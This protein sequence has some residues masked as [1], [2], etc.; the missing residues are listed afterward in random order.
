MGTKESSLSGVKL[1]FKS[2]SCQNSHPL[3]LDWSP[4][5]FLL[6]EL[7]GWAVITYIL[8]EDGN[9]KASIDVGCTDLTHSTIEHKV[10][11]LGSKANS[12]LLPHENKGEYVTVLKDVNA[13]VLAHDD[14]FYA[15]LLLIL[16][17][18]FVGICAVIDR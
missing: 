4:Y 9:G 13:N 11:A 1:Y 16:E 10:V 12:M 3:E 17:V 15:H 18:E 2:C 8:A 6:R 7:C 14:S 5:L